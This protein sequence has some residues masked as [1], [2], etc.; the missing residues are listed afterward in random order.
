MRTVRRAVAHPE[1][2]SS[3]FAAGDVAAHGPGQ[4]PGR[5]SV[6]EAEGCLRRFAATD[7]A[8][9]DMGGADP[10]L[11][12]GAVAKAAFRLRALGSGCPAALSASV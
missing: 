1:E 8:P 3:V 7:A 11:T 2:G 9:P 6:E 12:G 4:A 5:Y 10:V